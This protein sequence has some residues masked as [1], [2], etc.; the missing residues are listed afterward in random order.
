M[1]DVRQRRGVA[2]LSTDRKVNQGKIFISHSSVDKPVAR[3]LAK[4]LQSRGYSVWLDEKELRL[5]DPLSDTIATALSETPV[6]IALVSR[7]SISSRWVQFEINQAVERQIQGRARVIPLRIDEVDVPPALAGTLYGD[8]GSD[9]RRTYAR[10]WRTLEAVPGIAPTSKR[11][12]RPSP[13]TPSYRLHEQ[14]VEEAFG[15]LG[16]VNVRGQDFSHGVVAA[17]EDHHWVVHFDVPISTDALDE[18]D[19]DRFVARSEVFERFVDCHGHLLIVE[20][21]HRDPLRLA[22]SKHSFLPI[23]RCV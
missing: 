4:R 10:L 8:L 17:F 3:R 18:F 7:H 22:N 13:P 14:M 23:A 6:L 5:G 15:P 12:P 21:S 1:G 11:G 16:R 20:E 19:V 2:L 9:P